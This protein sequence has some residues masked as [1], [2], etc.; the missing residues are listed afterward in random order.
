MQAMLEQ[1]GYGVT[2]FDNPAAALAAFRRQAEHF[3]LLLTDLSMREMN[4][5]ELAREILT[6]RAG[7]PIIVVSGYDLAGI[8]RRL[9]DLGIREILTKPVQRDSLAI[10]LARALG[11]G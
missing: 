5:A 7:L 1:L 3:D 6:I 2:A 4:G 10:A 8:D 11:R 9:R